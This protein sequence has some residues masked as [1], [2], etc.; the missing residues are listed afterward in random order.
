MQTVVCKLQ[1]WNAFRFSGEY[2]KDDAADRFR[3]LYETGIPVSKKISKRMPQ[4][5]YGH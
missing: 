1:I 2:V 5:T 4:G 3:D